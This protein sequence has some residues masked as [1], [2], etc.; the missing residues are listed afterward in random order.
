MFN[1]VKLNRVSEN[2][3]EQIRRAILERQLNP[4]DRLPPERELMQKFGVSKSTLR[5]ALRALEALGVLEIR[6]GASGGPFVT[7]VDMNKAMDS[8]VNF[9]HFKNVSLENLTEVRLVL[10]PYTAGR[11]ALSITEGDL[12]RLQESLKT[13]GDVLKKGVGID[14]R[15]NEIEFHKIIANV[16][17]NPILMF[18][19]DFV[20]SLL[21]DT[22]EILQPGPFF[23]RQVQNAHTR[24][25][26]A[27]V[28][29]DAERAR[30]E[31]TR[32]V[33]EVE[34]GLLALQKQR[35]LGELN[36]QRSVGG[37]KH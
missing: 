26:K 21:I 6:Q 16:G 22:K 34:K 24:I 17:A 23:S 4:G 13:G 9:L 29:R 1:S 18:I 15:K 36:L 33:Q 37:D 28:E 19:I 25:Y 35:G 20:E 7:E 5:E 30:K 32:H 3:V 27:L 31:M 10:E 12:I 8:F 2:I 11:A 14:L